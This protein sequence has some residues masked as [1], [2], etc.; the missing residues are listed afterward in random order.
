[1]LAMFRAHTLTALALL[2]ALEG[3]ITAAVAQDVYELGPDDAWTLTHRPDSNA[4]TA[5]LASART[6]LAQGR[7]ERAYSLAVRWIKRYPGAPELSLAYLIK[8]DALVAMGDY[9]ESL[10]DYEY[11]ARR[12]PGSPEFGL[13]L[14]REFEIAQKF[15]GGLRRKWLGMRI[16]SATAEAEEIFI[17]VQERMPGSQLAERAG[18]ALADMYFSER[19][20][21]RAAESYAIFVQ[22]Y[23]RSPS[24]NLARRRLIYANIAAFKGPHFD[25][26]GL[27]EAKAELKQLQ[28]NRPAEAEQVGA[29]ALIARIIE[30]EAA[31]MLVTAR[32]YNRTNDPIA[33]EITVRALVRRFPRS[34]ATATA[35]QWIPSVLSQLPPL[36]RARTPN[37]ELLRSTLLGMAMAKKDSE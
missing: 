2:S 17:R 25:I 9:Y 11:V 23:P 15:A 12:Y 3:H 32:W 13:A 20:M 6:V 33:A 19:R 22:K 35:L 29:G 24:I 16:A 18:M 14:E 28:A 1:M 21:N 5:Q 34:A 31:K 7:A 30:S 37:Y 26:V 27:L 8:G 36:I 4:I 10:Y